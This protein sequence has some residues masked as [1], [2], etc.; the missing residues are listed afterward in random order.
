M[1]P[2]N[3]APPPAIFQ[4]PPQ[5]P[6]SP[7]PVMQFADVKQPQPVASPVQQLQ[8]QPQYPGIPVM[9]SP[10]PPFSHPQQMVG[11]VPP[12]PAATMPEYN[13]TQSPAAGHGAHLSPW[14]APIFDCFN[15]AD[16]CQ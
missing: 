8:P 5:M 3:P 9:G 10:P 2:G 7:G 12:A 1:H 15:P 16:Q 6:P 11:P 14:S 13:Q 4:V